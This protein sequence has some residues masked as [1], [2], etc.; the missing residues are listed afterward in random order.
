MSVR[1]PIGLTSA[2]ALAESAPPTNRAA[3]PRTAFAVVL[4]PPDPNMPSALS[5]QVRDHARPGNMRAT[6]LSTCSHSDSR[7]P[8]P[9]PRL[10]DGLVVA[11]GSRHARA[12]RTFPLFPSTPGVPPH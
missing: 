8:D 11:V 7:R 6:P 9:G 5:L 4:L 2:I 3:R 12:C 1:T 10:A